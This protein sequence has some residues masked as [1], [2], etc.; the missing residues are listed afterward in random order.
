[1]DIRFIGTGGAF[2]VNQVNSSALVSLQQ[3]NV[4]IDCGHSVFPALVKSGLIEEIDAV[5]ITHFH[6]DHVGSLSSLILYHD[7]ILQ[8]GSLTLLTPNQSFEDALVAFLSPSLGNPRERTTFQR[9]STWPSIQAIDTFGMH[10]PGM[11]TWAFTFSEQ[12]SSFAY[13]G[14]LGEPTAFFQAL[15]NADLPDLK[16][17]HETTY[18]EQVKAH[19]HYK[20]LESYMDEFEIYGY[21]CD[22]KAKPKD[23]RLPLVIESSY[24][25]ESIH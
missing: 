17:F 15:R 22:P 10:V 24:S 1:M 2:Q 20:V 3:G 16:V 9:I 25:I 8:K 4:L 18:Y 12:G 19:A 13:S 11:Q 6:D 7:L 5:L 14:D 21:H 23:M